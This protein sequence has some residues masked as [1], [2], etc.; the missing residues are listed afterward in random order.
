MKP[1]RSV[2][3]DFQKEIKKPMARWINIKLD[4]WL[5]GSNN[6]IKSECE[7]NSDSIRPVSFTF[8]QFFHIISWIHY[9]H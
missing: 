6:I 7:S 2:A 4:W 9:L 5:K 3:N 8:Y 1:R